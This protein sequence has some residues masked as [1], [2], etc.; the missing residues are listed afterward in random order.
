MQLLVRVICT[1]SAH[2]RF[3]R[4]QLLD[5]HARTLS[6]RGKKSVIYYEIALRAARS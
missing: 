6:S 4:L 1:S 3:P 2:I 5:G